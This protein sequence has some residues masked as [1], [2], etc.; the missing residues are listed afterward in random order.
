MD[1]I[2][3][4]SSISEIVILCTVVSINLCPNLIADV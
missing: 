4:I 3:S 1:R 2:S